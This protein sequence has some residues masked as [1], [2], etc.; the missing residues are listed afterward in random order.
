MQEPR[1]IRRALL[2]V[3]DKEGILEF[4]QSLSQRGVELLST[5]G[6]ARLLD[7]TGL[8]VIDVSDYTGF[9]EIM[10]G[11]IKTL[12]PK[13]HAGILGRRNID[14]K[15]M[16]E[17]NI[18]PIDIVVVNLYPFAT[19]VARANCTHEEALENIDIG[20]VTLIRS[21][22][23]NHTDVAIVINSSDYPAII[24]EMDHYKGFLSLTTRLNL[25]IKALK[26]TIVYDSKVTN[27][28]LSQQ[29]QTNLHEEKQSSRRFPYI[30]NVNF[31]KKQ[32]MRY[33]ENQHQLS[34]FY[35][36]PK[37]HETS[38][39]NAH[40]FQGKELSYNNIVDT[41]VALE[42][43]NTFSEKACVIVKHANPCGAAT[44]D[45][46]LL[47]LYNRAYQT[48]PTSA[49]GG[50]IAFNQPL[51]ADTARTIISRQFV[52]VII[53]PRINTD[54]LTALRSKKSIRVLAYSHWQKKVD[55]LDFKRI[56][57]GLLVQER[58]VAMVDLDDLE[59]VTKCQPTKANIRDSLFCWKVAKFV[60]SNAIVFARN[61]S[62]IG[63]GA[64]Q[65]SRIYS[66]KIAVI[67]AKDEGFDLKGSVMASDA[68]FPFRDS[69]DAAAAV[70]VQ[71]V[72]QPGGSIRDKEIISAANDYGISMIFTHTRHF[73]H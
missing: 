51:D 5:G 10:G 50:I 42:C 26:H 15:I 18:T 56:N 8:P 1:P 35:S 65:M 32:E 73:R 62:T 19:T 72:I 70:G 43:V 30:L 24:A 22:A 7:K 9:P 2:S 23:K 11:R 33:G 13:I 58:D 45:S 40:Q 71:C 63:I 6:T 67:K 16:H 48:D 54:A 12:H 27:Y 44:G 28:L 17:H 37:T 38:V 3:S 69:I 41:D 39:T 29:M 36:D 20:G 49:F 25:A 57:G 66:A 47:S 52:E 14:E 68:F 31:I 34:A 61:Q 60:K 53:A 64:G 21:A 59:V 55:V 4:A 46:L